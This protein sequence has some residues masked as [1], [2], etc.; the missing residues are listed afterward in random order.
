MVCMFFIILF[1]LKVEDN[2]KDWIKKIKD[3][4]KRT[5]D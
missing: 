3:W 4:F 1:F 5:G 2:Y